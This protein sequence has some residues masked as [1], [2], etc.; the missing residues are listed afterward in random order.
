MFSDPTD[1]RMHN[2]ICESHASRHM[3]QFLSLRLANIPAE[4]GS[5]ELYGYIAAR[6]NMNPLLN[7]IVHFSRDDPIILKQVC[8]CLSF[9]LC[10]ILLITHH[11]SRHF[12]PWDLIEPRKNMVHDRKPLLYQVLYYEMMICYKN[13][14][15]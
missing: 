11:G 3:L 15:K 6:D 2:G 8:T 7:Y 5:V 1:C 13:K 9:F 4:I 10:I 12:G 14:S